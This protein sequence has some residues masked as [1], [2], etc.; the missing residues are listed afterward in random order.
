MTLSTVGT[1]LFERRD[2]G[3]RMFSSR[4]RVGRRESP[5]EGSK[6]PAQMPADR[7]QEL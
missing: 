4:E 2:K 1:L 3:D 7:R 5:T 6:A